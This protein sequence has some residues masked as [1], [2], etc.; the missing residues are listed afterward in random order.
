MIGWA[1]DADGE[2]V[3]IELRVNGRTVPARC[4]A[5]HRQDVL[6]ALRLGGSQR[7]GWRLALPPDVW[8][9]G[10]QACAEVQL[11]A[12]GQTMPVPLPANLPSALDSLRQGAPELL[13][14]DVL[15]LALE[16]VA[17]VG[18]DLLDAASRDWSHQAAAIGGGWAAVRDAA[19]TRGLELKGRIERLEQGVLQGW[20][21][22][23]SVGDEPIALWSGQ[24]VVECSII[25]VE[26]NDVR[27]EIGADRS[28]LG[29]E[30]E[31]P[32]A[33][34]DHVGHDRSVD[35]VVRVGGRALQ[36]QPIS[37]SRSRVVDWVEQLRRADAAAPVDEPA[38]SRQERQFRTLLVLE[39]VASAGLWGAL[40][41][42]RKGF[43]LAAASRFGM[44]SLLPA[45]VAGEPDQVA[46]SEPLAHDV[47][48]QANWQLM[49]AFNRMMAEQP[50]RP[51]AALDSLLARH[52]VTGRAEQRFLWTV[53]P[54]FCSRGQYAMLRPRLDGAR[55]RALADSDSAYDLS[56]LLPEAASAG[57][58]ELARS[59][60]FKL[61]TATEG[62]LNTEC[63]EQAIRIATAAAVAAWPRASA[64]DE[65]MNEFMALLDD[66]GARGYWTRLHDRHLIR[67]L[68]AL[69]SAGDAWLP[70]LSRWA[71]DVVVRHFALVPD[72]WSELDAMS[73]PAGGWPEVVGQTRRE[74]NDAR[75]LLLQPDSDAATVRSAA[76]RALAHLRS[77]GNADAGVVLREL[78]MVWLTRGD[79]AGAHWA[80]MLAD[81]PHESLR[82]AAHPAADGV[83][84]ATTEAPALADEIRQL[85]GIPGIAHRRAVAAFVGA[86][87]LGSRATVM[88]SLL[89]LSRRESHYVGVRLG[90]SSWL[91]GDWPAEHRDASL[92]ELRDLWFAAFDDCIDL[93]HPPAALMTS[94]SLIDAASLDQPGSVNSR[95][96]AEMKSALLR[97]YGAVVEQAF[98][99]EARDTAIPMGSTGHSTL[100]AIYS[101]ERYLGTRVQAIRDSWARDLTAMG[102]PW[103]VVVGGGDDRLDGDILRLAAPDDYE[104]LPLKTLSLIRW[105]HRHTRFE[106]LIKIDDDCHL[107]TQAYFGDASYLA[108][109][110]HGRRLHRSIG[111]TD[112]LWHQAKSSSQRAAR[113]ADKTPEPSTYADGSSAYALSRY[114]MAQVARALE[115]TPGARLTRSAF[116][117][118][119]LLG[120]LLATRGVE[121][122]NEGHYTLIRRRF[123]AG[124]ITVNAW[125]NLF[126]PSACSPTVV[127]H[128]DTHETIARTQADVGRAVLHPARIWP[129]D[130]PI[131]LSGY[132]TNQLELV[133]EPNLLKALLPTPVVVV[134]VARNERLLMPHFL[135]HYRRLGVKAF[136][137]VDNL[138]DDGTREYLAAQPDVLLYSVD[139]EYRESHYGVSWQR[140]VLGAHALGRWVVLADIDEFLVYPDCESVPIADWVATL[141]AAG[142]DAA[143]VLMIDMYSEGR[144]DDADFER[145]APFD[146]C[147]SFDRQPLIRWH[148]GSGSFS[149]SP[150]WLSALRHR[151]IPD[152]APNIYTSQ[153]LAVLKYQPWVRLAEGLHYASNLRV[154]P[155]PVWFAH[156]K[157]HAGFRRKVQVEVARKQHFNN[158]EEYRKYAGMLAEARSSL[159]DDEVTTAYVDSRTWSGLA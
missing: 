152:S 110:Y 126:Y 116:L 46:L 21:W 136:I 25:R 54:Y 19:R 27:A 45:T 79:L 62:W 69:L 104:S 112:R 5:V 14:E 71:V 89:P 47:S 13:P 9:A 28:H 32:A 17:A 158:A 142:H 33:V 12:G 134:A 57:D 107:A 68:L 16:H 70:R 50:E 144:L 42:V 148:L 73:P 44:T 84:A 125:D 7:L 155:E 4:Q 82:F 75:A 56:L 86:N 39:H 55:L 114:A 74:F 137:L 123:G 60:M 58:F 99:S 88:S 147:R 53:L 80:A 65:F 103:V 10:G 37:L 41:P 49:R 64:I 11:V 109:H 122:S 81:A 100:V 127:T 18:P 120:D 30:I 1:A 29:F 36:S 77:K 151:L 90:A 15:L 85:S 118:D 111:A 83:P 59:A 6:D 153:K 141:D 106:H 35:L 24:Q 23:E 101:C 128:L 8:D 67:G 91:R 52:G 22:L 121:L 31:V 130:T 98:Q 48:T 119:K 2:P 133:S 146:V 43:L 63:V 76:L 157:Y 132:Q 115:S 92:V 149:N 145:A 26:R 87:L 117:E 150:T 135:A 139:T 94:A 96:A 97:R 40:E 154:A 95:V 105:V 140:A 38:V 159:A 113:S 156:F 34:W 124:G 61:R 143:R 66:T 108:H 72:F 131:Q 78:G 138:S 3:P 102:I 20:A 93:P 51:L 129:T